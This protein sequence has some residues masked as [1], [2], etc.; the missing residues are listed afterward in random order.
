MTA[1]WI[2]REDHADDEIDQREHCQ[3]NALKV[4][5]TKRSLTR[6]TARILMEHKDQSCRGDS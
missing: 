4:N 2:E 1:I 5:L 6:F 3:E